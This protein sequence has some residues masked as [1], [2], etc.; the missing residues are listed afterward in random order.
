[1]ADFVSFG[2]VLLRLSPPG[3]ERLIQTT[4]LDVCYGGSEAN[5]ASALAQWGVK[6]EHVTQFPDNEIGLAAKQS[7]QSYGVITNHCT[8]SNHRMG[9]YFLEHG[10]SLRAPKVVYDRFDSAF[11]NVDP[12]AFDWN[13]I[14]NDAKW[15]HWS[16]ITP[17]ISATAAQACKEAIATA[18]KK[19]II[20]SGDINYRRVLWQY[21]KTPLELMPELIAQCDIIVG[22]LTD[23]ENSLNIT[24]AGADAFERA[25]SEVQ[26]KYPQ[27]KRIFNTTRNTH[28]A[29][30]ND[31]QGL[32]CSGQQLITSKNYT[33]NPIV[34]RVGSG[35]AFMA[36][37]VY[38][39]LNKASD[40]EVL[41]FATAAAAYKHSI[42]GDVLL[43]TRDEI[44][45]II[46]SKNVGK[47]L[48]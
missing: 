9:V 29:S 22:G 28:H 40:A 23:F 21:G 41:E 48:R 6:G 36:G 5:I 3:A 14:L 11:A 17:A 10:S 45:S 37:V 31:L 26:K 44:D 32:L 24:G 30:H 1:M 47:L 12:S 42:P 16:G 13:E 39:S 34:D 38:Q 19:G 4:S 33:I 18:R 35:D 27:V 15:F 46:N 8:V 7:L 43:A 20:I 2:E 25:C